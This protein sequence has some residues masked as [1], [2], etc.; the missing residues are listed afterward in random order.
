MAGPCYG[1]RAELP[2]ASVD[3]ADAAILALTAALR[4]K[5]LGKELSQGNGQEY[6]PLARAARERELAEREEFDVFRQV[7]QSSTKKAN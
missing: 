4:G 2:G 6:A 3:G 7:A 5:T 1:S